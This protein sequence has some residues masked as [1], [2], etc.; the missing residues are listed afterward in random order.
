MS[1]D[2]GNLFGL[3]EELHLACEAD[4]IVHG[5]R[6]VKEI[7]LY[8]ANSL[9]FIENVVLDAPVLDDLGILED[10]FDDSLIFCHTLLGEGDVNVQV[11]KGS[12]KLVVVRG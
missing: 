5:R 8:L 4:A 3:I 1:D 10:G 2:V 6:L 7:K 12:I 11:G 9:D